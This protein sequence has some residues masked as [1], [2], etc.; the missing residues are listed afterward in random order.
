MVQMAWRPA[1]ATALLGG[2]MWLLRGLPNLVAL[3]PAGI[4]YV[5]ALVL[6]GAFTAEDRALMRRLLPQRLRGR[7]L[8]PSLTSRPS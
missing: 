6:L 1:L 4:V 8:I 3:V 7:R 2:T 5:V